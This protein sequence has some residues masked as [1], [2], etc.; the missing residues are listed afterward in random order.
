MLAELA[1]EASLKYK[2]SDNITVDSGN[3][4]SA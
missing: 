2:V 1:W 4:L 3:L